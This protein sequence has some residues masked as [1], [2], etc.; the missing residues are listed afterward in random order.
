MKATHRKTLA[1][2]LFLMAAPYS[3]AQN[4]LKLEKQQT[5]FYYLQGSIHLGLLNDQYGSR[6]DLASKNPKSQLYFQVIKKSQ[7][8]LQKGFV[9][10]L[11][12]DQMKLGLALEYSP[13]MD[14]NGFRT[15]S[16]SLV[17][18]D[19]WIRFRTKKDRTALYVGNRA[20]SYGHNPKVDG[21]TDFMINPTSADL[22]F[23]RDFGLHLQTPLSRNLD[24]QAGLTMGGW[25]N[26]ALAGMGTSVVVEETITT[27]LQPA[28]GGGGPGGGG[29]AQ[30]I[31]TVEETAVVQ[32]DGFQAGD[33]S[34]NGTWLLSGRVGTPSFKTREFGLIA[35]AGLVNNPFVSDDLL[36]IQRIG[37][38][39]VLKKG[40]TFKL[41]NQVTFGNAVSEA[42]GSYTSFNLQNNAEFYSGNHWMFGVSHSVNTLTGG[43]VNHLNH[44][45][46]GSL[47]YAFTTHTRLRLNTFYTKIQST[48]EVQNGVFLQFVTGIGKR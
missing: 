31:E 27:V 2:G 20:V 48:G 12:V 43:S 4:A 47:T 42:E 22:G 40:E 7:G 15:S 36:S 39:M 8:L 6:F 46:A 25:L 32:Q 28:G 23:S 41:V 45:I 13:S 21:V 1:A 9:A 44:S 10:G 16:T 35:A 34:Y 11:Q 5:T 3:Y 26:T 29:P 19:A 38:D 24:F 37:A 14:E 30:V 33:L 18:R 17:L